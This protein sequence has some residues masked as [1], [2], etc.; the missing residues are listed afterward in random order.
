MASTPNKYEIFLKKL[1]NTYRLVIMNDDT[2]EEVGSYRLSRLNVYILFSTTFVLMAALIWSLILFTKLKEYIPGYADSET[3]AGLINQSYRLD[4]LEYTLNAQQLYIRNR[5]K[6]LK[7]DI[8]TTG[9]SGSLEQSAIDSNFNV[10]PIPEEMELR[11]AV[12][13]EEKY[14]IKIPLD[15]I[16]SNN[17]EGDIALSER[18]LLPPIRG[19]VSAGFNPD[20]NHFGVDVIA[21]KNTGVK[22]IAAGTIIHAGW[23]MK[24]GYTI[25][26][27]HDGNLISIYKHNS[28]LTKKIGNFVT[29]GEA[30]A[31]IGNSGELTDGPHLHFELWH[32]GA[33]VNPERFFNF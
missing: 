16:R 10:S 8:D 22:S 30:I 33:P 23:D 7:D 19:M 27:Q 3:R 32:S 26:V 21:P 11:K 6:L 18:R 5:I 4:S 13:E 2:F 9:F 24:T 29:A 20:D 1:R 12:E 15:R 31:V 28:Y 25:S 17:S 14:A